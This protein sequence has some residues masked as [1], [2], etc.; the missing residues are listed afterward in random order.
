[1]YNTQGMVCAD[2]DNEVAPW[3]DPMQAEERISL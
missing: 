2:A 3:C 1:M